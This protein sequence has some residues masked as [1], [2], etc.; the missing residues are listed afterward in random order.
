[1]LGGLL[2]GGADSGFRAAYDPEATEKECAEHNRQVELNRAAARKA[3]HPLSPFE[4]RKRKLEELKRHARALIADPVI[5][6]SWILSTTRD[7]EMAGTIIREEEG[8]PGF[9]HSPFWY[10]S[11]RRHGNATTTIFGSKNGQPPTAFG[12]RANSNDNRAAPPAGPRPESAATVLTASVSNWCAAASWGSSAAAP[13]VPPAAAAAAAHS[14]TN[15]LPAPPPAARNIAVSTNIAPAL[16]EPLVAVPPS[17]DNSNNNNNNSPPISATASAVAEHEEQQQVDEG[18]NRGDVVPA[19]TMTESALK[20]QIAPKS[21]ASTDDSATAIPTSSAAQRRHRNPK[22]ERDHDE[23]HNTERGRKTRDDN[24]E[25]EENEQPQE[26]NNNN[27]NNNN[28]ASKP[29]EAPPPGA[30]SAAASSPKQNNDNDKNNTGQNTNGAAGAAAP[31]PPSAVPSKLNHE[32]RRE[33]E[34]MSELGCC[35]EECAQR[36]RLA[37][38]RV[39]EAGQESNNNNDTEK[40]EN[41]NVTE[42]DSGVRYLVG[43]FFEYCRFE[44]VEGRCVMCGAMKKDDEM[45]CSRCGAAK[46]SEGASG[47]SANANTTSTPSVGSGAVASG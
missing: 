4:A 39:E 22:H 8:V 27:N 24:N 47:P 46:G 35:P 16:E 45:K 25:E 10:D 44:K 37:Q 14:T 15:D 12:A 3:A 30:A 21:D 34:E 36:V 43:G 18:A 31:S 20:N 17:L 32:P 41:K 9:S 42:H 33:R 23:F 13:A 38:R 29:P 26:A 1:M 6:A 28:T 5:R 40:E 2:L 7:L 11:Q 19:A